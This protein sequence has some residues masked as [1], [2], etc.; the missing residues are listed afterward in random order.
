ANTYSDS[1][2]SSHSVTNCH[3]KRKTETAANSASA[4]YAGVTSLRKVGNPAGHDAICAKAETGINL[5]RVRPMPWA[6]VFATPK[7]RRENMK[8]VGTCAAFATKGSLP[9]PH[10]V[11]RAWGVGR[12]RG[13]GL[14][15][16]VG[17]DRGVEVGVA[18]GVPAGVGVA[19][20]VTTGVAVAVG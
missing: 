3:T 9:A 2:P 1:D 13:R 12:W 17:V 4:S 6:K 11:G 19:V 20:G 5:G 10:G 7:K 16:G 8:S 18:V 15:L 14:V